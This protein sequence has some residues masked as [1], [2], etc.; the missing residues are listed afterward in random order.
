MISTL[1]NPADPPQRQLEKLLTIAD[2]L[3]RRVEQ[4]TDDSGA[5]YAH[6]QRAAMLEDQVRDRTRDLEHALDLLNESNARLAEANQSAEAARQNLSNA[7][8]TINEG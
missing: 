3:M 1:I 4:A 8:E 5:A 6:F 7:I 2:V